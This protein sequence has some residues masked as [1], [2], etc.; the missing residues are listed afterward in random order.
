MTTILVTGGSGA[1]G[2]ELVGR[3]V[4]M[5]Y[6]VRIMSR[7]PERHAPQASATLEWAQ[8]NLETGRG[9]A[10]AVAGVD[11][12]IHAASDPMH[13]RQIDVH[14][15]QLLLTKAREAG[16]SH[17]IYISIVGIDRIKYGYYQSKLEAE[18]CIKQSGIPW[19]ILRATQFHTL[20]DTVLQAATK[21]PLILLPTDLQ[22]Q[23]LDPGEAANRL[24]KIVAAGPSGRVPDLGGPEVLT[25]KQLLRVWLKQRG[26]HRLVIQLWLPGK[27]AD[28]FRH[29]YNTCLSEPRRGTITWS[30]WVQKKY[31]KQ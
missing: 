18:E 10:Q 25:G 30:Q 12:I 28:G 8:G 13:A 22:F 4:N 5:S 7:N 31:G 29:G 11:V 1:L 6:N 23:V 26:M 20:I 2:R 17:F 15:T 3:L 16:V 14:G 19:S 9:L 21:L 24:C 27:A